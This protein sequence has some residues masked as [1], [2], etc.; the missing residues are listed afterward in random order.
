VTEPISPERSEPEGVHPRQWLAD[1]VYG[2]ISTLVAIAG[3]TFETHPQPLTSGAVVVVGAVAIWLAHAVSRL[4]MTR[5][6]QQLTFSARDLLD[7]LVGTWSIL[8]AAIPGTAIFGLAAA[9]L[10]SV[11]TAFALAEVVGALSL[12]VVGFGTAG[13]RDLPLGRRLFYAAG[14]TT[15]GVAIV[16]LEL[17]VHIL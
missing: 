8:A 1:Y 12:A 4:V 9:G 6:W 14:L 13:G 7:Q 11:K 17:V 16:A 15:V 3:L 10:W 2:S 5:S